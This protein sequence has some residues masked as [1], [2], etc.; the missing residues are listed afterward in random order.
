MPIPT[1]PNKTI[2]QAKKSKQLQQQTGGE[3][4]LFDMNG[5][6]KTAELRKMKM[7]LSRLPL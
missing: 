2:L 1:D 5:K 4:K 6:K 7:L 3:E